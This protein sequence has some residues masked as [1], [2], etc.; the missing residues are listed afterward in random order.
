[1]GDSSDVCLYGLLVIRLTRKE[2]SG[3]GKP[4]GDEICGNI[5]SVVEAEG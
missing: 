5:R 1:M 3:Q 2:K 4:S